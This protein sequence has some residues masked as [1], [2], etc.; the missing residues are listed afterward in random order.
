VCVYVC[1][2]A[3]ACVCACA[4][5]LAEVKTSVDRCCNHR[6]GML[7][8]VPVRSPSLHP[9]GLLKMVVIMACEMWAQLHIIEQAR[10]IN[11]IAGHNL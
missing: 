5:G 7:Y 9:R 10:R 6:Q 4:G 2:C 11:A 8:G 3:C 1:A